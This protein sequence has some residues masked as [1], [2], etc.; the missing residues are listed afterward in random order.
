[1]TREE[2]IRAVAHCV[3]QDRNDTYGSPENNF[4]RVAKLWSAYFNTTGIHFEP[5]DVAAM[6]A[7]L[8]IARIST[9]PTHADSWVDLAGYAVCGAEV[10]ELLE[11]KGV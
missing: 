10:S 2:A 9:N 11:V 6:L 5:H 1:M 4:S 7:L 3:L 8:K